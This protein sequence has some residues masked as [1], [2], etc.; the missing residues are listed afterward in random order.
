M[1]AHSA[2]AK[3]VR[4]SNEVVNALREGKPLPDERLEALHQFT[5]AVVEKRGW[6]SEEDIEAFLN[7]GFNKPQILEVITGVT[8]KTL[9]NYT[10][11][12]AHTPLDEAF[13]PMAWEVP[14]ENVTV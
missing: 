7:A 8:Q 5:V 1:A 11:H 14:K 10:N 13:Q 2:V 12:I 6:V 9:S 4:A 3:M